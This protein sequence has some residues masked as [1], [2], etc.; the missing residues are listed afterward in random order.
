[1]N[2]G[3]KASDD[4]KLKP[5]IG[6]AETTFKPYQP[7]KRKS[8]SNAQWEQSKK[9]WEKKNSREFKAITTRRIKAENTFLA[10]QVES[11]RSELQQIAAMRVISGARVNPMPQPDRSLLP[12]PEA[13]KR[14]KD[15]MADIGS[16]LDPTAPVRSTFNAG[17]PQLIQQF[18]ALGNIAVTRRVGVDVEASPHVEQLRPHLNLQTQHNGTIQHGALQ[19]P[20]HPVASFDPFRGHPLQGLNAE[21]KRGFME[22][23]IRSMGI[24]VQR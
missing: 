20:H 12:A 15:V 4:W 21:E 11:R 6:Q 8:W 16:F 14:Y 10:G 3:R 24:P 7:P 23:Y 19:D 13:T 18:N 1:M 17:G 9:F 2:R 5:G 22:R